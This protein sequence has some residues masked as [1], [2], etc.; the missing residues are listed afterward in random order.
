MRLVGTILLAL[1]ACCSAAQEQYFYLSLDVNKPLSNTS[2]INE[3]ASKGARAGFRSFITDRIS[4][5]LDVG[6]STFEQYVPTETRQ[7][8]NGAITSDYFRYIYSYS[9]VASGQYYF[10]VGDKDRFYPYVGIG[11]GANTNEYVLYYNIYQDAERKWGFLARPEAGVLFR[12][13]RDGSFGLMGAVHYDYSTNK[14]EK[15]NYDQ[16]TTVGFQ[17]GIVF[18]EL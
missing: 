13:T 16:F 5:G 14:S 10:P 11:V 9:F 12:L 17:L 2:W 4:A 7:T 1:V 15:F 3:S 18:L 8:G 6:W